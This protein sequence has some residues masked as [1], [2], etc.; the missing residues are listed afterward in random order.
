MF[1]LNF[2]WPLERRNHF[3]GRQFFKRLD[4]RV[5]RFDIPIPSLLSA[6][7]H[8]KIT[9]ES[10]QFCNNSV[11]LTILTS[12]FFP[13]TREHLCPTG[14]ISPESYQKDQASV[15]DYALPSKSPMPV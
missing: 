14:Q 7:V 15:L 12:N 5:A 1:N 4:E 10:A 3:Q 2:L 9:T 13:S 6:L 8:A 11:H